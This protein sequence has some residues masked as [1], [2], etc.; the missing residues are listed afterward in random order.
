MGTFTLTNDLIKTIHR[1][2][3]AEG[4]E[5]NYPMRKLV[6]PPEAG[7]LQIVPPMPPTSGA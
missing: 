1:C 5:I 4:I 3:T 2:L 6:V 7:Q